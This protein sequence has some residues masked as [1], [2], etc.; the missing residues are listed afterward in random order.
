[1][2][3][4]LDELPDD[5]REIIIMRIWDELSFREIAELTGKS[6]AAC[7]MKFS[8]TLKQLK[9]SV[10]FSILLLFITFRISVI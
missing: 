1:M 10:P 4:V 6:E 2:K 3:P 5:K 7:K 9:E 8:R